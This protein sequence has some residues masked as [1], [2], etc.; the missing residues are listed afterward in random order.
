MR[1]FGALHQ[2]DAIALTFDDTLYHFDI[3]ETRPS[4]AIDINNVDIE[5]EFQRT[6]YGEE[7]LKEHLREEAKEKEKEKEKEDDKEYRNE[8][9]GL[10]GPTTFTSPVQA[11]GII[12]CPV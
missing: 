9:T 3:A 2:G 5:V 6:L 7:A 8:R 11:N 4:E 10:E 12:W 1:N